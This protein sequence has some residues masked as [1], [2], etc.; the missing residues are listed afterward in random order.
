[1]ND[2]ETPVGLLFQKAEDYGKTSIELMK[3]KTIDKTSEVISSLVSQLIVAIIALMFML[4]ISIGIALWIGD[5]LGKSYLGFMIV[6]G[7]YGLIALLI[8]FFRERWIKTPLS[9]SIIHQMIK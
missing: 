7:A 6:A 1:M 8:Y 2:H 4:F 5:M 3:L 9:N